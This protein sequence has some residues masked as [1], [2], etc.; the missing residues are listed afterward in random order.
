MRGNARY[1]G[2]SYLGVGN[3]LDIEQGQYIDTAIDIRIERD[4]IGLSIGLTNLFNADQNRF[5]YGNPFTVMRGM[6]ETP[7]RPRTIR[8][9]LDAVF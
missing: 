4:A 1:F 5:S 9:G 8:I 6:Q 3:L 2:P 7:L